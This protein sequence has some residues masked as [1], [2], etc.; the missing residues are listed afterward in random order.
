MLARLVF[1]ATI[2]DAQLYFLSDIPKGANVL[3]LG[4]GTGWL[5]DA[6]LKLNPHCHVWY[7]EASHRMLERTRKKVNI[8]P[9]TIVHFIHGTEEMIP[10]NVRFNAVI[11][12]FYFDLFSRASLQF[13]IRRILGSLMPDGKVLVSDFTKTNVWKH[14]LLLTI[15]YWF[16]KLV[17]GI[18]SS[19]LP[20]WQAELSNAGLDE[21]KSKKF[22]RGF[23]RSSIYSIP[24]RKGLFI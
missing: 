17:C 19:H 7:V 12:N 6:L 22:Y 14:R 1:G 9:T 18:E 13:V 3:I 5:L 20:D 24:Q 16:F 2:R 23:I 4:G 10:S 15:M 11:T 21:F 8:Q